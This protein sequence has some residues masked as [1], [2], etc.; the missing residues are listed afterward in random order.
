MK[1]SIW[2]EN[3]AAWPTASRPHPRDSK[4]ASIAELDAHA[5]KRKTHRPGAAEGGEE[6]GESSR[7]AGVLGS[8]PEVRHSV[9]WRNPAGVAVMARAKRPTGN[10]IHL[11][12]IRDELRDNLVAQVKRGDPQLHADFCGRELSS[13]ERREANERSPEI[14]SARRKIEQIDAG[15]SIITGKPYWRRWPE[16]E[17][18]PGVQERAVKRVF[19]DRYDNV[20][21][22]HTPWGPPYDNEADLTA[23]LAELELSPDTEVIW[24]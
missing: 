18:V 12:G 9:S 6:S 1:S 19:I 5:L 3:P 14:R 22:I 21:P 24:I 17:H 16:L 4:R 23:I 13:Q 20:R 2:R 7:R 11:D 8:A 10:G 15:L